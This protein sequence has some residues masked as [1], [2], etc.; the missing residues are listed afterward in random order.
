MKHAA[1]FLD[2][3]GTIIEQVHHL[4]D[5]AKV[6]LLPGAGQAIAEL[7]AAGYVCVV[8]T[9]QSVIGRGMLTEQGLQAIHA[10]M[11]AQLAACGAKV[12]GVY[13]CPVAP[14]KGDRTRCE[15]PDRK[16]SPGML[17]KA[18]NDLD[19]DLSKSWMVGDMLSDILAG[20]HAGCCGSILVRTGNASVEDESHADYVEADLTAAVKRIQKTQEVLL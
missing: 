13:F 17:L 9:N 11:H 2:R 18:A 12:D 6:R 1:V 4:I 19:L 8:V 15:H 5:P 20:R 7:T 14:V 3:D 16:P 10:Q